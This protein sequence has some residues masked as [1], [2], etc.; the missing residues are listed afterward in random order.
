MLLKQLRDLCTCC[1]ATTSLGNRNTENIH[2]RMLY[3]IQEVISGSVEAGLG[4]QV[5]NS[6]AQT[7]ILRP[8]QELFFQLSH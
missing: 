3:N 6:K 4:G 2:Q 8:Y 1:Y 7:V 5:V